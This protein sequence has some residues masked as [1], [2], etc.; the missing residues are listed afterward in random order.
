MRFN[1]SIISLLQLSFQVFPDAFNASSFSY[2]SEDFLAPEVRLHHKRR[3]RPTRLGF[4]FSPVFLFVKM[5]CVKAVA[6]DIQTLHFT[7]KERPAILNA[8]N[9]HKDPS[10]LG[11]ILENAKVCWVSFPGK[12]LTGW[13]A[14]ISERHWDSVACVFLDDPDH[15]LGRHH[16]LDDNKTECYCALIYGQKDYKEFGYLMVVEGNKTEE[17]KHLLR[18]RARAMN[19]HIV[20]GKPSV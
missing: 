13:I 1:Q 15:G 16:F 3:W 18:K 8:H 11:R 20:F 7:L 12:Y 14:L 9:V 6:Q 17:E 19:A 10:Y 4:D 5:L 2:H